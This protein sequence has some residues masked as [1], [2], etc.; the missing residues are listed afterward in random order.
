MHQT[1]P[2]TLEKSLL[3]LFQSAQHDAK[4]AAVS[5]RELATLLT[6]HQESSPDVPHTEDAVVLAFKLFK[7]LDPDIINGTETFLRFWNQQSD[8]LVAVPNPILPNQWLVGIYDGVDLAKSDSSSVVLKIKDNQ[9][10]V[11]D[12]RTPHPSISIE[13]LND[14]GTDFGFTV[15]YAQNNVRA[16]SDKITAQA[17]YYLLAQKHR[18]FCIAAYLLNAAEQVPSDLMERAIADA[19]QARTNLQQLESDLI[20]LRGILQLYK[21]R[22]SINPQGAREELAY[23]D[24]MRVNAGIEHLQTVYPEIP[25]LGPEQTDDD[26]DVRPLDP[27]NTT[28]IVAV[29]DED[30]EGDLNKTLASNNVSVVP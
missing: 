2:A 10:V 26:S 12:T 27:K 21:N 1:P 14:I 7:S 11:I 19:L 18:L 17:T 20:S 16:A 24:I 25:L 8:K 15:Y 13:N 22:P 6:K 28:E 4:I 29:L 23:K 3:A 30:F 9:A 5:N